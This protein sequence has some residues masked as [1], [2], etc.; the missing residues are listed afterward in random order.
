MNDIVFTL[1]TEQTNKLLRRCPKNDPLNVISLIQSVDIWAATTLMAAIF[2][3]LR[4][5]GH[6]KTAE[7]YNVI[8]KTW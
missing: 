5:P 2:C 8:K 7:Y 4:N 3:H 1:Q 6:G